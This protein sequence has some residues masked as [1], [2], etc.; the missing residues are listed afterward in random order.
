MAHPR[1]LPQ[2]VAGAV[3]F[4]AAAVNFAWADEVKVGID[5]FAFAPDAVTV[6]PGD[7]VVFENHDDIPHLVVDAA[8]KFRSKAL[9]T[10]DKFSMA[11]PNAGEFTYFCGLHPKMKGKIIVAP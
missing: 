2:I 7:T 10:G 11:F 8:G 5:N 3:F 6:K 9:D 4:C 1:S